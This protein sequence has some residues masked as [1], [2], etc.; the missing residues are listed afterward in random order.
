MSF[1]F[2]NSA[3]SRFLFI[4]PPSDCVSQRTPP[5]NLLLASSSSSKKQLI[6]FI[7]LERLVGYKN[8]CTFVCNRGVE[9]GC[10]SLSRIDAN[11]FSFW[12][13]CTARRVEGSDRCRR[14]GNN[15]LLLYCTGHSA[16]DGFLRQPTDQ[17]SKCHVLIHEGGKNKR[18]T[19][20]KKEKIQIP[21]FHF[22]N[23]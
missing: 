23:L 17:S 5:Y 4:F 14:K 13:H 11:V 15:S 19:I 22:Q 21:P 16:Q 9:P 2:I 20:T 7:M 8:D 10:G 1:S 18:R 12:S 3:F 6:H